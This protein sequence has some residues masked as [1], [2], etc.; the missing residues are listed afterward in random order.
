MN[1]DLLHQRRFE[2]QNSSQLPRVLESW[3]AE[4]ELEEVF[5][6]YSQTSEVEIEE[7]HF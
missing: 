6:S 2:H 4:Q 7:Y 5:A 3:S 1:S